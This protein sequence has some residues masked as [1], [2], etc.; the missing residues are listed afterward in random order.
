M[1]GSAVSGALWICLLLCGSA[2]L[3]QTGPVI[4]NVPV[5]EGGPVTLICA[6]SKP[7][8]FNEPVQWT[9]T[10]R[11]G[12]DHTVVSRLKG[13]SLV[14]GADDPQNRFSLLDDSSLLIWS[15]KPGDSG[16][17]RCNRQPVADLQVTTGQP[18]TTQNS[19]TV[20]PGSP[21]STKD[22][23]TVTPGSPNSTKDSSTVTPGSPNSTKDSSTVTPGS[24]NSTKDPSTVTPGSPNSTKGHSTVIPGS[25]NSTKDP[26]IVT[27]GSPNSTKGHSTVIPGSPNSTK[28]P[29]IVTPGSP[30]STKDPDTESPSPVLWS[31]VVAIAAVGAVAGLAAVVWRRSS[32][33]RGGR[34]NA[35]HVYDEINHTD[36]GSHNARPAPQSLY[37]PPE[38]PGPPAGGLRSQDSEYVEIQETKLAGKGLRSQDSE[39]A[40]IQEIKLAGKGSRS[41]DSEYAEIQ[42][43]KLAG[44][45]PDTPGDPVYSLAQQ[46]SP[47]GVDETGVSVARGGAVA[48]NRLW[49]IHVGCQRRRG[50]GIFPHSRE[51]LYGIREGSPGRSPTI[52][53]DLSLPHP[54]ASASCVPVTFTE[55]S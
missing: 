52:R 36:T 38:V 14:K 44:K 48:G 30:N 39:Y 23:S 41:Q 49:G 7:V 21:N 8:S 2:P 15:V 46:P 3:A 50:C 31:A 11:G 34:R 6:A 27:R 32:R 51:P 20:T 47:M 53:A 37:L 9:V 12:A 42:E 13:G 28:D 54:A 35:E 45:G 43:T 22:H 16:L 29:N 33:R 1:T 40:E 25:P 5:P 4:R 17:Y 26:N 24:P 19:S 18:K 10:L 55:V